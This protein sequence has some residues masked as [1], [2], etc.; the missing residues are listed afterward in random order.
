M[1]ENKNLKLFSL[2]LRTQK[3]EAA[4]KYLTADKYKEEYVVI[5]IV[6]RYSTQGHNR[7]FCYNGI[8]LPNMMWCK[9]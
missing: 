5:P 7:L 8:L 3:F 2:V 9:N 6:R 1:N 4:E